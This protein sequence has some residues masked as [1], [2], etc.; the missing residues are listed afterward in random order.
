MNNVKLKNEPLNSEGFRPGLK[1]LA[2]PPFSTRGTNF[3]GRHEEAEQ[4]NNASNRV[5]I[6][7]PTLPGPVGDKYNPEHR[8]SIGDIRKS[9]Q[10]NKKIV[11]M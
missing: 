5:F 7:A 9:K 1:L 8:T 11:P 3:M 2:L 6:K 4:S 10:T